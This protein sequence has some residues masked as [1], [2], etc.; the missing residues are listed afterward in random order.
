MTNAVLH[1]R[2][3]ATLT[4]ALTVGRLEVRVSDHAMPAQPF[5]PG[6]STQP[7]RNGAHLGDSGRGLRLVDALTDVWGVTDNHSGKQVWFRRQVTTE[8]RDLGSCPCE[9]Q[10][11]QASLRGR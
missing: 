5:G 11:V 7:A 3:P 1:A 9:E 8:E 4:L 10:Q 6:N 2:T